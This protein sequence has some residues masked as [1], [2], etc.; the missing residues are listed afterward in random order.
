MNT[1]PHVETSS[2]ENGKCWYLTV[3]QENL[4]SREPWKLTKV[5][6]HNRPSIIINHIPYN[7]DDNKSNSIYHIS[8]NDC[9]QEFLLNTCII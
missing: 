5:E 9:V 8:S 2:G 6:E 4:Y 3:I 7:V 1:K